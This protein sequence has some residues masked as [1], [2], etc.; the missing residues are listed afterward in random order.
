MAVWVGPLTST[1]RR[2][3]ITR[4]GIPVCGHIYDLYWIFIGSLLDHYWSSIWVSIGSILDLLDLYWIDAYWISI[5]SL[6][7]SLLDLYLIYDL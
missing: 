5:G 1:T 7:G 3:S 2:Y 6:I 4:H